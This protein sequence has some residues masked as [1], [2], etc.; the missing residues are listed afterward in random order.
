MNIP[1]IYEDEWLLIVDKPAGLLSIPAPKKELRNLTGVLNED[2]EK[3]GLGYR[4]HPCH[5]LDRDTSG[6]IIYAKGKSAQKKMMREFKEKRVRKTYIAFLQG[7]IP[8]NYGEIR[9]RIE[10]QSAVTKY[11]VVQRRKDF[12]VIEALPLTGRTNQLRMHFKGIGHPLVGERRFAFRRD[13]PLRAKRL[14]LHAKEMEFIHPV[15]GK[16]L[17]LTADLP[18]DLKEFLNKHP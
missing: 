3:K 1:V 16:T 9:R 14:C 5:R 6:I 10:G 17:K 2:L 4:L 7:E 15:T 13:F 12:S 8:E 18:D 11:R